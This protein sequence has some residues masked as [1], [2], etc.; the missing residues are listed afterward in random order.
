MAWLYTNFTCKLQERVTI[1]ATL[2][3]T[4]IVLGIKK[5]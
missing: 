2:S 1:T 5:A 4:Q 3:S